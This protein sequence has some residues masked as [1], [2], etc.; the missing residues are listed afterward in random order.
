MIPAVMGLAQVIAI[1]IMGA[2]GNIRGL[3]AHIP[4]G[5]SMAVCGTI[6]II[7]TYTRTFTGQA[8]FIIIFGMS[9]GGFTVFIAIV[10]SSLF[11]AEKVGYGTTLCVQVQGL[12]ALLT[13]PLSGWI[14]DKTDVYDGAFWMA[15]VSLILAAFVAFTFPV[16]EKMGKRKYSNRKLTY[17][18]DVGH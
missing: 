4:Y 11:G 15:G 8:I 5:T 13:A 9:F 3:R 2:I 17:A 18:E 1:P 10:V 12:I 16:V 6:T 7:S 14:R